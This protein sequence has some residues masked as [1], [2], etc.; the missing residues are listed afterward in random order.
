M[1]FIDL[2]KLKIIKEF[3]FLNYEGYI[4]LKKFVLNFAKKS[5][6]SVLVTALS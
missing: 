3:N 2:N 1:L 4:K 6:L 5:Q